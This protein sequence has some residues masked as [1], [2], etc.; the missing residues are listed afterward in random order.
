MCIFYSLR[1][2]IV[3][4]LGNKTDEHEAV[5][6]NACMKTKKKETFRDLMITIS[7]EDG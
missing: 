4:G 3:G 7:D 2:N 6:C 1:Y 5:S